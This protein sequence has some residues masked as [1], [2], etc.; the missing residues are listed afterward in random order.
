[1]IGVEG[2]EHLASFIVQ[3]LVIEEVSLANNTISDEGALAMSKVGYLYRLT[4]TV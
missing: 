4:N 3:S 1:M 2:A